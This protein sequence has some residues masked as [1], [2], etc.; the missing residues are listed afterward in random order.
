MTLSAG[1]LGDGV[2][3]TA[4]EPGRA[5]DEQAPG[6][7]KRRNPWIWVSVLLGLVA[8][9]LLIWALSAQSDLDSTQK[10]VDDLQAD[11]DQGQSAGSTTSSSRSPPTAR[12]ASPAPERG[13]RTSIRDA[14]R[15][16]W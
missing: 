4:P 13:H 1:R 2:A 5:H 8:P 11:V 10:Q 9:G 6:Q 3:T 14:T 7:T 12:G 15:P 16:A